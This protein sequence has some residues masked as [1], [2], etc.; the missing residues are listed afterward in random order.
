MTPEDTLQKLNEK[1]DELVARRDR[2]QRFYY[3][4][5]ALALMCLVIFPVVAF[6]GQKRSDCADSRNVWGLFR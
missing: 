4:F 6:G 1:R 5:L 2:V 3:A